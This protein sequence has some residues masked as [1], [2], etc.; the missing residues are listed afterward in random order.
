MI[1]LLHWA[2]DDVTNNCLKHLSGQGA[3]IVIDNHSPVP[4]VPDVP[5]AVMRL[6]DNYPIITAFNYAM[7]AYPSSEYFCIT[8]DTE[9]APGMIARLQEV[10]DDPAVGIVAPGTNDTGAGVLYVSEPG[11]GVDQVTNHVDNTAWGFRHDLVA[12]IGY[13]DCEGHTLRSCWGCNQDY[14]YRARQAGY[15][16]IAV[17]STYIKHAHMG[18]QDV[19]AWAAGQDWLTRKWGQEA[20]KVW[21]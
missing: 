7:R 6:D 12:K 20:S 11:A 9:P 5:V 17:R 4:F 10:L 2:K 21:A 18:G 8:N 16:V 1:F 14:A 15:K 3:V 19:E 13:P